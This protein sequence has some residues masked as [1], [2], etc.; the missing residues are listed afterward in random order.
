MIAQR[1][2]LHGEDA[3][4]L[5]AYLYDRADGHPFFTREL[6][7]ALAETGALES[8]PDGWRVGTWRG[9]TCRWSCGR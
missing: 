6:L 1:H 7:R 4:R 8:G 9:A 2:R 3:D 5:T